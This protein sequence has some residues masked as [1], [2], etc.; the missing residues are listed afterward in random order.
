MRG[1]SNSRRDF[2][3]RTTAVLI[4]WLVLWGWP[5]CVTGQAN[6]PGGAPDC[7]PAVRAVLFND[8]PSE[9]Q[10]WLAGQK[11]TSANFADY[12]NSISR[13][14]E[15]REL[16]G[17]FDH[18]IFYALQSERFTGRP[19]IEPAI[20]AYEFVGRLEPDER[21]RY[22]D[23]VQDYLPPVERL[24][25]AVTARLNDFAVVLGRET[26]D[27]RLSYF[28]SFLRRNTAPGEALLPRLSAEYARAMKF[29]YRKEF[30]SRDI[31]NQQE[32]AAYVAALYQGRG[33]ST[34]TQIEANFAI[35]T[36]LASIAAKSPGARLNNVLVIG[37]GL[38]FAPR[39]DLIDLFGPQS[40]QPFA[41]ADALLGLKLADR[42]R[43]HVHCVDINERVVAYLQNFPRRK[44]R[45]LSLLSGLADRPER[46]LADDY[47][48]YFRQLGRSIGREEALA[49]PT[50]FA[51]HPAKA[52]L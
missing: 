20:S 31:R 43:L 39:T 11:T 30:L 6:C 29:L 32:L 41:V 9:F 28:Q 27:E 37:P 19:K 12:I 42:D 15:E 25:R 13:Q 44:E 7:A 16:R 4:L 36:A 5:T 38:D 22:L 47:K 48:S 40:Y 10:R 52:V 49:P 26:T 45:K 21:S 3:I 23:E 51:A 8:L 1:G 14:T 50:R 24:P 34:D 17:E 33:H 35:Y 18:L 46:P 2:S